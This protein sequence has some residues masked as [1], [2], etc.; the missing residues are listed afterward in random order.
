MKNSKAEMFKALASTS[1][2]QIIELLKHNDAM[3]VNELADAL[4]ISQPGVLQHLRVLR[5][6]ELVRTDRKG[7]R[8]SN[9][10]TE[11]ID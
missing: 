9:Y 3:C 6:V 4:E 8:W 1:R 11:R 7:K 2:L 5:N 10:R